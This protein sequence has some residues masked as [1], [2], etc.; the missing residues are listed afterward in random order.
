VGEVALSRKHY[1]IWL[2]RWGGG[3]QGPSAYGGCSRQ[4]HYLQGPNVAQLCSSYHVLFPFR[5]RLL[6]SAGS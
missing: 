1:L 2:A 3:L 4:I 5:S 6:P